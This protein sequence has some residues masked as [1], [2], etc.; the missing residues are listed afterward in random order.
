MDGIVVPLSVVVQPGEEVEVSVNFTAPIKIGQYSS[1][2][3]MPNPQG[4]TFG[5]TIYVRII[6]Q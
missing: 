1:T 3:V 6:V 5:K 4:Y 2:W